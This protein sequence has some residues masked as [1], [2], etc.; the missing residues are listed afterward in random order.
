MHTPSHREEGKKNLQFNWLVIFLLLPLTFLLC[1]WKQFNGLYG[2]EPHELYRYMQSLFAFLQ[3]GP[4]PISQNAPVL[5]PL[6]GAIVS[7][8]IPP[9][10]S[11]QLVSIMSAGFCYIFFCRVL[12]A[13]YP[14]GTQRQRFA[15]LAL[16]LSPFFFRAAIV[17]FADM[18]SMAFLLC[19]LHEYLKWKKTASSQSML[20]ATCLA[21]LAIQT[22]YSLIFLLLPL[23]PMLWT[24]VRSRLSLF[25]ITLFAI[26]MSYTPTIFLKGQDGLDFVLH[27][28][29]DNWSP[30]NFFRNSFEI[31][32]NQFSYTLP[33]LAY[34]LSVLLHPGF[35]II[36]LVFIVLSLRT[37]IGLPKSWLISTGIFLLFIAGL[38]T[39]DLRLLLPAFPLV[40]LALY[41]AYEDLIYRFKSRNQRVLVYLAA[42]AVQLSLAVKVITPV[43]HYQQEELSIAMALKKMPAATLNTFAIDGALRTY[44]VPQEIV[45]MWSTSFPLYNNGDLI[46][47]NKTRFET[48]YKNSGPVRNF[49]QLRS[50]GRL[51]FVMSFTNGW[52]LYRIKQ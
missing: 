9:H 20:L 25:L 8:L 30:L 26:L 33:N 29:L 40:L 5:F 31:G 42:V 34:V 43:I 27:P 51:M 50:G 35:C 6:A 19:A 16:F 38:P 13:L 41:P 49:Q 37:G 32:A 36:G 18:L 24:A 10:F 4:S 11:L 21:V 48:L 47:F 22:R 1:Y 12:N 2:Q 3:G 46:L 14:G 45:N 23:V 17:G 28:W 39:Q 44:E 52:E 7:L 15:F